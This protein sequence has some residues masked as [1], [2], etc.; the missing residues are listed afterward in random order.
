M[1]LKMM[2]YCSKKV[3]VQAITIVMMSSDK[4]FREF[5]GQQKLHTTLP[6]FKYL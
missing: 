6:F 3:E 5:Y 2:M 1:V 4:D